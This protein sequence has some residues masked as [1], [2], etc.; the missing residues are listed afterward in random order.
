MLLSHFCS[1]PLKF[2]LD[3]PLPESVQLLVGAVQPP[4]RLHPPAALH[5]IELC[6]GVEL[7]NDEFHSS[8]QH[9]DNALALKAHVASVCFKC[10][11]C[12]RG[13]L[14][15]F[16]MDVAKLDRECCNGCTRML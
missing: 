1:A 16:Y 3:P 14:Q 11:I 6:A 12:L 13:T 9:G 10:F 2:F 5:G 15:M 7:H 8:K 4:A